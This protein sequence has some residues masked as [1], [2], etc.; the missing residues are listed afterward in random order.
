VSQKVSGGT[1]A[2]L[3]YSPALA[4]ADPDNAGAQGNMLFGYTM[5]VMQRQT[6]QVGGVA[7]N[8]FPVP[9]THSLTFSDQPLKPNL[10]ISPVDVQAAPGT[11]LVVTATVRSTGE[12]PTR[13][14]KVGLFSTPA[15]LP[16]YETPD[17]TLLASSNLLALPPGGSAPLQFTLAAP[18][19]QGRLLK[20]CVD[21]DTN[22]ADGCRVIDT[23]SEATLADNS[24]LL[25][26]PVSLRVLA[27]EYNAKGAILP[28]EITQSGA[29][30]SS[31]P[32]T[33]SLRL[34]APDGEEIAQ[35]GGVFPLS[36]VDSIT[37]SASVA[38]GHQLKSGATLQPGSYVVYWVL[39]PNNALG[40]PDTTD[41]IIPLTLHLLPDL[42]TAPALLGF[43]TAPG[44]TAPL[45]LRVDNIGM[46]A[47]PAAQLRVYAVHP[48]TLGAA[49]LLTLPIAAIEPGESLELA[50]AI[51]LSGTPFEA[52]GLQG[53][54]VWIDPLN[55][56]AEL[57]E[58]NNLL[59]ASPVSTQVIPPE[60]LP[61]VY[62]PLI[63]TR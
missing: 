12:L 27:S 49:P 14:V 22:S 24:A 6:A 57:N 50:G 55:T 3:Q 63:R 28:I 59:A 8:N 19:A 33:A 53:L 30:Y 26:V 56:I 36:P 29:I 35:A 20:V 41:N 2:I 46:V 34:G 16:M 47:S 23:L 13:P 38:P 25:A 18:P 45:S 62:L 15:S 4:P 43:G 1:A 37:L 51:P 9:V 32:V 39:D 52:S 10:S 7:V 58:N 17:E 42:K 31:V 5:A 60:G 44:A 40:D 61:Q 11:P 21:V 54:Y 48:L